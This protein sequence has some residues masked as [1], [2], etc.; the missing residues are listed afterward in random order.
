M[1]TRTNIINCLPQLELCLVIIAIALF[2]G[3]AKADYAE[4]LGGPQTQ[5]LRNPLIPGASY[6]NPYQP[7]PIGQAPAC[8]DGPIPAPL[9]PGDLGAPMPP[10]SGLADFTHGNIFPTRSGQNTRMPFIYQ[11]GSG[12]HPTMHG[13]SQGVYESGSGSNGTGTF[14]SGS[15]NGGSGT[16]ESG[17]G[18]GGS[19]TF[20]SGGGNGGSGTFESGGGNG[21]S[22][23]F[24]SGGGNGGTQIV[25]NGGSN[26]G[27]QRVNNGGPRGDANKESD[28]M[29]AHA[30]QGNAYDFQ[31]PLPTVR[32]FSRYL[33]ILGV[34]CATIFIS[35]AA[36]SMV[37]GSPYGASRVIGAAGGLILLLMGYTIWKVVQMNTFNANTTGWWS[38][39]RDGTQ[40][41][42]GGGNNGGGNAPGPIGPPMNPGN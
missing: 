8:G 39:Y 4:V 24:E 19:G 18:N 42:A 35:L 13:A 11:Q 10:P 34:V 14:E 40:Q 28:T 5:T 22:G 6:A 9:I 30:K 16:F 1:I 26:G 20:E 37:F 33:V 15:G 3:I 2:P 27:T 23:T 21:G 41:N 31:G 7:A 32:I 36:W 12:R 17:G 29:L 38:Q 25:D